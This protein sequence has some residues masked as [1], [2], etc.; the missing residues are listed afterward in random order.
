MT[1]QTIIA[2]LH[3]SFGARETPETVAEWIVAGMDDAASRKV[4]I[5]AGYVRRASLKRWFGW[6]AMRTTF[7]DAVPME[8]QLDK[9]RELAGLFLSRKLAE[10]EDPEELESLVASFNAA[11]GKVS[12]KNSFREDRLDRKGRAALGAN[13]LSRRRY[14][15]LFRLAGRLER[16]LASLRREQTRR[17]LI[18]V[19]KA[20][21]APEVTLEELGDHLPTAAF[22]A[23]YAARMKLRSEF[24]V[25][26]QQKP[27][28]NLAQVLLDRC[29]ADPGTRWAAIARVFPRSDVLARLD[30]AEKGRLLGRWFDILSE[31]AEQLAL[32]AARSGIDLETMIVRRGN[33]SS[34]WNLLAGAWNRARDHWIALIDA[35]ELNAL[36]DEMLPGKV[37]RLMAADVAAWHR[38]IGQA[39]HPDTIVWRAL[40]KPWDVLRAEATCTRAMVENACAAAGVNPAKTGWSAARPRTRVAAF[41]PTPELVHGVVVN[42][43]WLAEL[44]RK[45]GA[46]SGKKLKAS[47]L[48]SLTDD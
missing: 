44:F 1:D 22:I 28:D 30:D 48:D 32:A 42:N 35:L 18:L 23:Y 12:G 40:P 5:A 47:K 37:M 26:G 16:R 3:A 15:K 21:L 34:T 36:L 31:I 27:F 24:T 25:D 6:T 38:S 46:F 13:G 8:R 11:I 45:A 14:T 29:L 17:R 4:R 9:A 2:K 10:S 20:A 41:R 19:G 33:D 43:P 7:R 39:E